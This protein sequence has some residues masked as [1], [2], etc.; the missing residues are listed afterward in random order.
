MHLETW[1]HHPSP[2]SLTAANTS[3]HKCWEAAAVLGI[4]AFLTAPLPGTSGVRAVFS[5]S[6]SSFA[7]H[8]GHI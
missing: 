2:L 5:H 8:P 7:L 3:R 6:L 4:G 1:F